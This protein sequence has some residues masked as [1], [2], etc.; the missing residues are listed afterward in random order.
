MEGL[1]GEV[2]VVGAYLLLRGRVLIAW[3]YVLARVKGSGCEVVELV[4]FVSHVMPTKVRQGDEQR[5]D[6]FFFFSR[7]VIRDVNA[8]YLNL[9]GGKHTAQR[10]L[11]KLRDRA[12]PRTTRKI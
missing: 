4:A 12:Q 3:S 11:V 1:S 5:G 8:M 2:V 9:K 10:Q 7:N 6:V